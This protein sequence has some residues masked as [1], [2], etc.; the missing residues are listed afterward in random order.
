MKSKVADRKERLLWSVLLSLVPTLSFPLGQSKQQQSEAFLK[1][2]GSNWPFDTDPPNLSSSSY[3]SDSLFS[4]PLL[5]KVDATRPG[6]SS[7]QWRSNSLGTIRSASTTIL[8]WYRFKIWW[9]QP[10]FIGKDGTCIPPGT[11]AVLWRDG[12]VDDM[13]RFVLTSPESTLSADCDGSFRMTGDLLSLSSQQAM[14]YCGTSVDP[15]AMMA[16]AMT[17]DRV[18]RHPYIPRAGLTGLGW[19]TWNAFYTQISGR[20]LLQA[21]ELFLSSHVPIRWIILDDG[22]QHTTNEAGDVENG[23]QWSQRLD[24]WT[25]SPIKFDEK[26]S[27]KDVISNIKRTGID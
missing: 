10:A 4:V 1:M 22:W 26:L 13:Y 8:C 12:T 21:M 23:Q 14:L 20:S 18:P 24:G 19:C 6:E 7:T 3:V 27:L 15:Y 16:D 25:A 17:G 11:I 5:N 9:L 2:S